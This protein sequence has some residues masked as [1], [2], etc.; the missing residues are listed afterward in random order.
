MDKS[1]FLLSLKVYS[2]Y[3]YKFNSF[4]N[5]FIFMF[6]LLAFSCILGMVPLPND[7]IGLVTLEFVGLFQLMVTFLSAFDADGNVSF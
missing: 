6:Q 7:F 5:Y 1:I 4:D 3:P 2:S